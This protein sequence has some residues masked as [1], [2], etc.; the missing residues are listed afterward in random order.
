MPKIKVFVTIKN[1][2][3]KEYLENSYT[4]ILTDRKLLYQDEKRT[5]TILK[6]CNTIEMITHDKENSSHLTFKEH[7]EERG[8]YNVKNIGTLEITVKTSLLEISN[9]EIHICYQTLFDTEL[10]GQFDFKLRYEVI[11]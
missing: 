6:K 1:T 9:N 2:L 4:G 5:V 7:T 10:M 11:K 3:E 8:I